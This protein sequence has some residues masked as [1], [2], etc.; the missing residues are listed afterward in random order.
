M[1]N[2]NVVISENLYKHFIVKPGK[3]KVDALT[4]INIE[5]P[6]GKLTALIGPDGAGKTTFMRLVC[7]LMMPSEG[8]ITVLGIN[9]KENPQGIQ[10]RISYMPQRFGLY[11]D[12]SIQENLNLY[13]DLYG[14]PKD[15]RDKRFERLL[16]M[17]GLEEFTKRQAGKLS[18]GMKQKLGLACTLVRSPELLLLDEPTVGVDPLSRRELWEILQNLV[19]DE[20][21]TVLV[22]TAY[23]DEAE[24]CHKVIV[25]HKSSILATGTPKELALIGENRC[26]KIQ[27][28]AGM[29]S[30]I[31]QTKLLDDKKNIV[32]AVPEGGEVRFITQSKRN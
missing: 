5:V 20:N 17:T 23:M 6:A 15:I 13:A 14:V 32:D 7:G 8:N 2:E 11:E 24:L 9:T 18:G 3:K 30:R 10:D 22:N 21:L 1:N 16:K 27:P 26:Y 31:L 4:D 25:I 29:P 12:L 19:K 28:P